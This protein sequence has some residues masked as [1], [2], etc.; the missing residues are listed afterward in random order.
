MEPL[1]ILLVVFV[2]SAFASKA[3]THKYDFPLSARI[4]MCTMLLFTAIG[5]YA[6]TKGM[7]MMIPDFIPLKTELVY[8]TGLLE[9]ALGIA[10]LFPSI[11]V[12]TA[13]ILILF[14]I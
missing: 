4:A 10:L 7:A 6:F 8:L 9:I 12:Y 11:R 3:I 2:I 13:W 1:I 14:F 5:H